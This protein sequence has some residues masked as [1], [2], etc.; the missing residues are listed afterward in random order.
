MGEEEVV[1]MVHKRQA[2]PK[3]QTFPKLLPKHFPS[4]CDFI[5]GKT[6]GEF[7]QD[8]LPFIDILQHKSNT[9]VTP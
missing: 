5:H 7:A 9:K 2:K 6:F 3:A 1:V 8:L 4:P